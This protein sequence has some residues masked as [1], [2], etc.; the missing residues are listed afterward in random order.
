MRISDW[1]SDVCSS[2]LVQIGAQRRAERG[3]VDFDR[4]DEAE[5]PE[6]GSADADLD[7]VLGPAE[8]YA[9]VGRALGFGAFGGLDAEFGVETQ[10]V[11]A[12]DIAEAAIPE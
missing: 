2:V 4:D 7:P 12:A 8:E 9:P 6:V 10:R 5:R 3:V 11:D 1:S